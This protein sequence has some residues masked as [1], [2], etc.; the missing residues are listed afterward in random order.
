MSNDDKSVIDEFH[1][2][3]NMTPQELESWLDTDESKEVEQKDGDNESIGLGTRSAQ[4]IG[5]ALP[6]IQAMVGNVLTPYCLRITRCLE[7]IAAVIGSRKW[8]DG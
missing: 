5:W 8:I 4:V 7:R 3:V 1:K 2:V 6:T